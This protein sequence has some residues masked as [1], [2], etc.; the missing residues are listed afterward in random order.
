MGRAMAVTAAAA[1]V[2]GSSLGTFLLAMPVMWR[3]VTCGSAASASL[4]RGVP[5]DSALDDAQRGCKETGERW[6]AVASVVG[7]GAVVLA[8]VAAGGAALAARTWRDS[9]AAVGTNAA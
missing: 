9:A 1:L 3:G 5:D 2:V 8:A 4:A 6:V 7:V